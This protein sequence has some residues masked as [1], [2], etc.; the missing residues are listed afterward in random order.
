MF[1]SVNRFRVF[2]LITV[3]SHLTAQL[4][5][6]KGLCSTFLNILYT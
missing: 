5:V 4:C 3:D 1:N 2:G 6:A